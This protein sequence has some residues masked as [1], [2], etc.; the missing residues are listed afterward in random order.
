MKCQKC[1]F[2]SPEGSKFCLECGAKFEVRCPQ[3]ENSL[4]PTAKFCN[5]C[6]HQVAVPPES[7]SPP[8]DLT[9]DDKLA[10]IQRYHRHSR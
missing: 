1:Q 9:P 8:K 3:C 2:D 10:N 7:K 5:E 4:P 6:G